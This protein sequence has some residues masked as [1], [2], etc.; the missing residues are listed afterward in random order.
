MVQQCAI[1]QTVAMSMHCVWKSC[2]FPPEASDQMLQEISYKTLSSINH[3]IIDC[4]VR[5]L[6][7]ICWILVQAPPTSLYLTSGGLF[8]LNWRKPVFHH[9][10]PLGCAPLCKQLLLLEEYMSVCP[11]LRR[12]SIIHRENYK[13]ASFSHPSAWS[14]S[15]PEGAPLLLHPALK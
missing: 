6:F 10:D 4:D 15:H 13:Q 3:Y 9:R 12:T 5:M 7:L 8:T 2:L 14:W 11:A 1:Y